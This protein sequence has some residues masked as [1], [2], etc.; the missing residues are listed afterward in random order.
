[1]DQ[2]GALD[3]VHGRWGQSNK[4]LLSPDETCD[5]IGVRRST[6]FKLLDAGEIASIKVGRL[7]RI[8]LSSLREWIE[9]QV[10]EQ[11]GV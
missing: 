1:M 6:L 11:A 2:S 3:A 10:V 5:V 4:L 9:R 7:R 8:P